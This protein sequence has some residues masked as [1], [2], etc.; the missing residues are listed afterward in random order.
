MN[1]LS[2]VVEETMARTR[3]LVASRIGG[4]STRSEGGYRIIPS[5]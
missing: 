1:C 5:I 3:R 4:D 2:N